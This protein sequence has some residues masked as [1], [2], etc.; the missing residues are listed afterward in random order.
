MW[1][2]WQHAFVSKRPASRVR[3]VSIETTPSTW[4]RV[5]DARKEI[6]GAYG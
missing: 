4:F 5:S 6:A 1:R 2:F 3:E